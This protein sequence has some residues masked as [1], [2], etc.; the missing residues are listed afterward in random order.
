MCDIEQNHYQNGFLVRILLNIA[1]NFFQDEISPRFFFRFRFFYVNIHI[2]GAI[3]R[4]PIRP[5]RE[6]DNLGVS[7]KIMKNLEIREV[8]I[9][10]PKDLNNFWQQNDET[11]RL[12]YTIFQ[13]I[14]QYYLTNQ[15]QVPNTSDAQIPTTSDFFTLINAHPTF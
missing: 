8:H 6:F 10:D 9:R 3:F 5:S 4:R 13:C 1:H 7:C 2:K 11:P 14:Y 12:S 15:N